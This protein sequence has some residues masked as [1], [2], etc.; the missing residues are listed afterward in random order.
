MAHPPY[1]LG[2]APLSWPLEFRILSFLTLF[3]VL[4]LLWF[5]FDPAFG[6]RRFRRDPIWWRAPGW[7]GSCR[8]TTGSSFRS[9]SPSTGPAAAWRERL[10]AP[11]RLG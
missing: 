8:E 1:L 10:P 6:L 5:V 3:W 11:A 2:A 9:A 4:D 7:W